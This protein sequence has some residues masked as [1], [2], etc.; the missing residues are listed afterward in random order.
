MRKYIEKKAKR[1]ALNA[2]AKELAKHL[3]TIEGEPEAAL[4]LFNTGLIVNLKSLK[5]RAIK[6]A[7]EAI[8]KEVNKH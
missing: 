1:M 2:L 5:K 4:N 7:R 3:D 6:L 8:E